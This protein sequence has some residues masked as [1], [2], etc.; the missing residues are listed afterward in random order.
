V[1]ARKPDHAAS[2]QLLGDVVQSSEQGK[3]LDNISL[4]MAM[5]TMA[6]GQKARGDDK[7]ASATMEK[8]VEIF[9]KKK[10]NPEVMKHIQVQAKQTA[11][12]G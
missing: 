10:L 6:K 9:R 2:E 1:T 8:M 12:G 11:K 4:N 7:A 5:R 3:G